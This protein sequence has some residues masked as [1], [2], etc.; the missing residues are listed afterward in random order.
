MEACRPISAHD[1]P[2]ISGL[3]VNIG[4]VSEFVRFLKELELYNQY[5]RNSIFLGVVRTKLTAPVWPNHKRQLK[6]F[7][8]TS[9]Y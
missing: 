8:P 9:L 2:R 4:I 7:L 6:S 5:F 1:G 3:M